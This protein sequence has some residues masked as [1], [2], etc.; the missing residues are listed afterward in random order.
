MIFRNSI[1]PEIKDLFMISTQGR[2][3]LPGYFLKI[4]NKEAKK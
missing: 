1:H 3:Y 4:L 2:E